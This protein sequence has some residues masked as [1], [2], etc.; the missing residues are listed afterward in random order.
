MIRN[1]CLCAVAAAALVVAES[2]I[3]QPRDD[4][5][6][7]FAIM[8]SINLLRE[9]RECW[10]EPWDCDIY[11]STTVIAFPGVTPAI[12]FT[13]WGERPLLLDLGLTVIETGDDRGYTDSY[14]MFE[15]GFSLDVAKRPDKL[16]PYAGVI[17]GVLPINDPL[18][19]LGIQGGV[20]FFI[21][22]YATTR[23][24]VGYRA[25]LAKDPPK[26]RSI[27]VAGGL[28]FFL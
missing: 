18:A 13:A 7:E 22:E 27:E 23:L 19:F 3:A 11:R 26:Y 8:P 9:E 5:Q 14:F 6:F 21:R 12:R 15:G 16:R 24:Q 10:Y 17:A 4:V 28:S 25:T 2:A 1:C 20:R